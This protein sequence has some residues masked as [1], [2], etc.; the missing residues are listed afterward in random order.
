MHHLMVDLGDRLTC[1]WC[2][3]SGFAAVHHTLGLHQR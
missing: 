3:L 1:F 2:D